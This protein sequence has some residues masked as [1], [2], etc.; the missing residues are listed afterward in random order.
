MERKSETVSGVSVFMNVCV[1]V[2]RHIVTVCGCVWVLCHIVTV[3]G[4]VW[5]WV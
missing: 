4:C 5:V 2:L 1:F 3:C